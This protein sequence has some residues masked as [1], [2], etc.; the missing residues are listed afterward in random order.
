MKINIYRMICK[1]SFF[2]LHF[3]RTKFH[4]S[5]FNQFEDW[6]FWTLIKWKKD[7]MTHRR[8]SRISNLHIRSRAKEWSIKTWGIF[9]AKILKLVSS[10]EQEIE[11]FVYLNWII[12]ADKIHSSSIETERENNNRQ[13][14]LVSFVRNGFF[15]RNNSLIQ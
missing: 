15:V 14:W 11:I 8:S 1:I 10:D 7:I 3:H 6:F 5:F 12:C 9:S 13:D 2:S 4:L